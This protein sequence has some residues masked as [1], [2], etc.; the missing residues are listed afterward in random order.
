MTDAPS[1]RSIFLEPD[2][3]HR[4]YYGWA[5][6][7]EGPGVTWLAKSTSVIRRYVALSTIPAAQLAPPTAL[8][9]AN[10]HLVAVTVKSFV[11]SEEIPITLGDRVLRP[12]PD[13]DRMFHRFTSVIDLRRPVEILWSQLR[14]QVRR[15]CRLAVEAGVTVQHTNNP[16]VELVDLFFSRY[17]DMARSR[18]LA[19]PE[20]R[21]IDLMFGGGNLTMHLA[22]LANATLS[23][24]LVYS[25][26]LSSIYSH[27][28]RGPQGSIGSSQLL[29]WETIKYLKDRGQHWYD[30]GGLVELSGADGIAR[31]KR[32]LGG[33][34]LYMGAEYY[35][36]API[37]SFAKRIRRGL[38]VSPRPKPS[39]PSSGASAGSGETPG[40]T[41]PTLPA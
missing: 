37:V 36:A 41:P 38:K 18:S 23:M 33:E 20:R 2:W 35:A 9:A 27:G 11:D 26:G 7:E 13:R 19:M 15:D 32:G 30:L 10:K 1:Y 17:S 31:F 6:V 3:A 22:T 4:K 14:P 28:L 12:A 29:Q 25:A 34:N 21:T 40:S 5:V 24:I 39:S 16:S 8:K